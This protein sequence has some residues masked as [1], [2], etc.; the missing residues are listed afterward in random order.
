MTEP[1]RIPWK[2]IG[3]EAVAIVASILVAFALD[4]WW[5]DKQREKAEQVV[6]Q[7]LLSDFRGKQVLLSDMNQFSEAI[8]EAVETLLAASSTEAT[9]SED[10]IDRLIGDTWWVSNAAVWESAP[11]NQL[12]AGGDL[13]IISNP[14]LVQQL[15]ELQVAIERVKYHSRS[16]S[17]F[18]GSTMT[19]FMISHANMSQITASIVHRPGHPELTIESRKLG[20]SEGY[21]H[22]E[23]LASVEFQNLLIAKMEHLSNIL[24]VGHPGVSER[25]EEVI[26]TLEDELD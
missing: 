19:P 15:A 3:V 25:L 6:L 16:E 20:V 17:E 10:T 23:L 12:I 11:L 21:R 13:S 1:Q 18:H 7:T 9:L 26:A 14:D 5:E 4:A 8:M 2:R 22:S 24:E